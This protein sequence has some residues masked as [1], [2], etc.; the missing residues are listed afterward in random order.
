MERSLGQLE[1]VVIGIDG[2]EVAGEILI[3]A[4]GIDIAGKKHIWVCGR[5]ALRMPMSARC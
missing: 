3:M 5:V 1:L 4:V 2:I